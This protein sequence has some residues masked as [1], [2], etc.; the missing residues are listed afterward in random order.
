M[1]HPFLLPAVV[2]LLLSAS[3]G[4]AEG[5]DATLFLADARRK[6]VD[7]AAAGLT[8]FSAH[9]SLRRSEEPSLRSYREIAG[10]GYEWS[11]TTGERF[12]FEKTHSSLQQ[13]YRDTLRGLYRDLL[14]LHYFD[15]FDTATDLALEGGSPSTT[16]TG[17]T[18]SL[19]EVRATFSSLT[20]SFDSLDLPK[21]RTR[22]V[23]EHE[24][25]DG[26]LR[27]VA[28]EAFVGDASALRLVLGEW[29]EWGG[30]RLPILVALETAKNTVQF[31][32]EYTQI[33]GAPASM[34]GLE[35]AE[36][37]ARLKAFATG[38]KDWNDQQKIDETWTISTIPEDRV[39]AAVAKPGLAD[40]QP[41]VRAEVAE[42]LGVMGRVNVVPALI[43]AV[44]KNEDQFQVHVS[45]IRALGALGDPR[46][47]EVLSKDWWVQPVYENAIA[48]ANE[49]IRAL[50][51]IRHATAVDALVDVF[52][53]TKVETVARLKDE[54]LA[55]LQKLTGQDLGPDPRLWS[56]WWK[57]NRSRHRFD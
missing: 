13:P 37:D 17:T 43:A 45:V 30:F 18:E 55:S 6:H 29:R 47:V 11:A 56:E 24:R 39:A 33:N 3:L 44:K 5:E 23:Y 41:M 28:H 4:H 27:I 51:K 2:G 1:R 7:L 50:G 34:A 38:W 25:T 20:G 14:G 54:L 36:V 49:R 10:L 8:S 57:K 9:L 31:G 48:S 22:L 52:Y 19:G 53:M 21:A 35:P 12:A 15:L 16:V 26:G 46:A 32:I 40:P 42:A